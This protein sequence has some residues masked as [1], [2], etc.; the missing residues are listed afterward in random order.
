M[1]KEEQ[2]RILVE[3]ALSGNEA[4]A[5]ELFD[6]YRPRLKRLVLLRMH[7]RLQSRVDASDVLQ[8]TYLELS[9]RL[10][11]YGQRHEIPFYLWLRM[12]AGKQLTHLHRKHLKA[13]MRTAFR[14]VNLNAMS[15]PDASVLNLAS[16]LA[17]EFTSVD[18]GLIRDELYVKLLETI[19][20]M[21]ESDR[22]I[23]AMRNF[24]ELSTEEIATVLGLTR[25]GVLKRYTRAIRRLRDSI[26]DQPGSEP[27]KRQ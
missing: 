22:E 4:A 19:N 9:R 3:A 24:E 14:E 6:L 12:L 1:E 23:V 7:P 11:E 16:H 10:S 8:D 15:V 5:A 25:S 27:E 20:D 17:G 26:V 21:Q 2:A 13:E 18:R